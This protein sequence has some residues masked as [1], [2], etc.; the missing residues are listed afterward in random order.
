MRVSFEVL[1]RLFSTTTCDTPDL[2]Q[3]SSKLVT[4]SQNEGGTYQTVIAGSTNDVPLQLTGIT[5]ARV[6]LVQVTLVD[7][8]LTLGDVQLKKNGVGGEAWLL[9][10]PS[11]SKESLFFVTTDSVVSLFA[12]NLGTAAIKVKVFVAG[13]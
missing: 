2:G 12:S 7:P 4:D 8:T 11:G 10:P 5:T 1:A 3:A 9:R 6:I 13:D